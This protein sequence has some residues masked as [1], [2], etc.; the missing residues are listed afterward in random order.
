MELAALQGLTASG[1]LRPSDLVWSEGMS[2]WQPAGQVAGLFPAGA[3]PPPLPQAAVPIGYAT[4]GPYGGHS[5]PG[6]GEDPAARWLL[7]VGR[8]G[9]AIAAGYLGLFSVLCV[10]AP[11]ALICGILAVRAIRKDP[12]KHGMGRAVFGIIM[13]VLGSIGLAFMIVSIM[14]SPVRR[15]V[16]PRPTRSESNSSRHLA[17]NS[18]ATQTPSAR[19][20]PIAVATA[21]HPI[22]FTRQRSASAEG[23]TMRRGRTRIPGE[24]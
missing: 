12:N 24:A 6:L 5:Q 8:S 1:Q 15:V 14:A 7:P 18:Y 20:D 4:P 2:A 17:T 21:R 23:E 13:G 16:Q 11:F 3:T 19:I 22:S 9:W 10:P